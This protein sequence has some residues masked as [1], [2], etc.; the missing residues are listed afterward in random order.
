MD[1][2]NLGRKLSGMLGKYKHALIVLLI[3]LGLMLLPVGSAQKNDSSKEVVPA[4]TD[5]AAD[6]E[7]RLEQI[8]RRISGAGEVEVL[9]TERTGQEVVYQTDSQSDRAEGSSR[10]S[11]GTVLVEDADNQEYGLIRR[12]DP[13]VY[14]GAVIVCQGGD[15]PQVR[16]AIV[17]AVQCVTGLG[18]NQISVVK[19]G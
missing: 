9:L 1:A 10:E 16:L 5:A 2:M 14:L 4:H 19:M 7:T 15:N 17:E 11:A 6:L 13:P 12:T 18:A 3:G 8:L